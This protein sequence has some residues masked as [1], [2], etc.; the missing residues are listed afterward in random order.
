MAYHFLRKRV[1]GKQKFKP[2]V[3]YNEIGDNLEF[4]SSNE[5]T[6][7]EHINQDVTMLRS[8]ITNEIIGF[9]IH[10]VKEIMENKD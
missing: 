8:I 2:E 10:N 3:W 6:V 4:L 9:Q 1:K 7:A 5:A